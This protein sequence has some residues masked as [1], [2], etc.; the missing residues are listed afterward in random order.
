MA[1]KVQSTTTGGAIADK[2]NSIMACARGPVLMQDY[3]LVKKLADENGEHIL[4]PTVHAKA[5]GSWRA[6]HYSRHAQVHD[7]QDAVEERQDFDERTF[8]DP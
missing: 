3:R 2:R 8:P 7:R 4:E 1:D 6:G 5:G